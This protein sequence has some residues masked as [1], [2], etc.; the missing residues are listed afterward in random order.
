MR[1]HGIIKN[2]HGAESIP[3][4]NARQHDGRGVIKSAR[5]NHV[6]GPEAA[7]GRNRQTCRG[8]DA[9]SRWPARNQADSGNQKR[10]AASG[11]AGHRG[12]V[13]SLARGRT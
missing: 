4:V 13:A 5:L 1:R 9:A 3:D 12:G 6:G 11:H 2:R 7:A 8:G 10:L